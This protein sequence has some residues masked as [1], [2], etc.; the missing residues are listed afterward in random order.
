MRLREA[1]RFVFPSGY[2]RS[3]PEL[4]LRADF[5]RDLPHMANVDGG[6]AAGTVHLRR[7][8]GGVAPPRGVGRDLEPDGGVA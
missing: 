6:R 5:T 8:S 2:P 1:V 7:E 4:S 3:P